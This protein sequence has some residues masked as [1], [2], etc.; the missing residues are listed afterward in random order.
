MNTL[1]LDLLRAFVAVAESGGF[2]RAAERLHLT[3]STV[4]QQIKRLEQETG[5]HLFARSTRRVALTPDG[6]ILLGDARRLLQLEESIRQR[7][8]GPRLSGLVRL[9]V[10]EELTSGALPP[11]LG[12]FAR[13][14][15][16]VRLELT[17]GVSAELIDQLDRGQLDVVLAKRP[18][19]TARGRVVWHEPLVWAAAES[20]ALEAQASL[21]LAFFPERSITREAAL[22]ALR[23][24]GRPWHIACTS[25]SLSGIR[26]VLLA[27]LAVTCLART[28]IGPGLRILDR[29]LGLPPLPE[30]AF[31]VYTRTGADRAA[32]ALAEVLA[33]LD[34]PGQS[35]RAA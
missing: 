1:D 22:E 24:T 18:W 14:H 19:G 26:A 35:R 20:F 2:R 6:E 12:R 5:Q 4:S 17:I 28:A 9:G 11:A 33:A 23:K 16:Q 29:T 15:P 8:T 10:A 25:P 21:P 30:I 3:Q 34:P 27:G 13:L 32:A 7:L 31:A